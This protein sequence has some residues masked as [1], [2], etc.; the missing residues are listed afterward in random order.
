MGS[1][2]KVHQFEPR[3]NLVPVSSRVTPLTKQKLIEGAKQ[4]RMRLSRY[5][6]RILSD[7]ARK[8]K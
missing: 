2:K 3:Q 4:N 7:H 8:L 6:E 1:K 5:L